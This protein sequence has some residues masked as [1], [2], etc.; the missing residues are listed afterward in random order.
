MKNLCVSMGRVLCCLVTA[1]VGLLAAPNVATAQNDLPPELGGACCVT[2]PAGGMLCTITG[3][4]NCKE[5]GGTWLGAGT[6]C[7]NTACGEPPPPQRGACCLPPSPLALAPCQFVTR[8]T[9]EQLGGVWKGPGVPCTNETC[10]PPPP[11]GACCFHTDSGVSACQ[12]LTKQRC[13]EQGGTYAGDNVA[14]SQEVCPPGVGACC[15]YAM[16]GTAECAVLTPGDCRAKRGVFLGL[17]SACTN[18]SCP[19]VRPRGRCC[20]RSGECAVTL[21]ER[22]KLAGGRWDGV[23]TS[24][25]TDEF[26]CRPVC[27]CDWNHDGM[28][29]EHDLRGFIYAFLMGDADYNHDGVTDN[30][31][32]FGFVRCWTNTPADCRQ[33]RVGA[34][35]ISGFA[36]WL[37][38]ITTREECLRATGGHYLGDGTPCGTVHCPMP[39]GACCTLTADGFVCRVTTRQDCGRGLWRGE[40]TSCQGRICPAIAPNSDATA[41]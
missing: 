1:G 24:C 8:E 12:I 38:T 4:A 11:R 33:P 13:E 29:D 30:D 32:L 37:C 26:E 41:R 16:D 2:G 15:V 31:D 28:V 5:H 14:C 18:T 36:G 23:G 27:P 35:C 25:D 10:P 9:C 7:S 3:E 39:V 6:A 19:D 20:L 40:G 17:G 22:C 21:E 34:C